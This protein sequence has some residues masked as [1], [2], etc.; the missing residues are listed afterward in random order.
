VAGQHHPFMDALTVHD[1]LLLHLQS[2]QIPPSHRVIRGQIHEVAP[3]LRPEDLA[4]RVVLRATEKGGRVSHLWHC[5]G[6]PPSRGFYALLVVTDTDQELTF[7]K[8]WKERVLHQMVKLG[9]IPR[10][11]WRSGHT[12]AGYPWT[13]WCYPTCAHWA[14]HCMSSSWLERLPRYMAWS[15][16]PLSW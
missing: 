3:L 14:V 12:T 9:G 15:S 4:D 5:L 6:T 11:P 16:H 2:L 10:V 7:L 8:S 13:R 1:L